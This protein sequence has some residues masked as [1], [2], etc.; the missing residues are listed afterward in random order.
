VLWG[1]VSGWLEGVEGGCS[2][3]ANGLGR[4]AADVDQVGPNLVVRREGGLKTYK[5]TS[6]PHVISQHGKKSEGRTFVCMIWPGINPI[7]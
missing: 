7:A 3:G 5:S 2:R 1:V 4:A 6:S